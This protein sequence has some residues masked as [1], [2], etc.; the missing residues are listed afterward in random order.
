M[1]R[2]HLTIGLVAVAFTLVISM[3]F[4]VGLS[5]GDW[6]VTGTLPNV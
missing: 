4:A 5:Y 3:A 2:E 1:T 6:L